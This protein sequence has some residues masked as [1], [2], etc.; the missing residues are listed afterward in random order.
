MPTAMLAGSLATASFRA[1][2]VMSPLFIPR[3]GRMLPSAPRVIDWLMSIT[4]STTAGMAL[5]AAEPLAH[6]EPGVTVITGPPRPPP[7]APSTLLPSDPPQ[8]IA[9]KAEKAAGSA[10]ARQERRLVIGIA[11]GQERRLVIG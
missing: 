4:I 9:S 10:W 5:A 8:E 1:A 11:K 7:L 2:L 3:G 6:S